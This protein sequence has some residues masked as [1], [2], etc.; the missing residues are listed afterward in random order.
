MGHRIDAATVIEAIPSAVRTASVNGAAIDVKDFDK[1]IIFILSSAIMS[2]ADTL[3]VKI[4]DSADGATGWADVA[5][6]VF[7]QVTDAAALFEKIFLDT[8]STRRYLRVVCTIAGATPSVAFCVVLIGNK[9]V[10]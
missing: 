3:D 9:Q 1:R 8:E 10:R 2:A 5:G 4:Q 7:T 6:A